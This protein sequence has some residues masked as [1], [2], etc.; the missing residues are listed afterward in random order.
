MLIKYFMEQHLK[1][2]TF[3][4]HQKVGTFLGGQSSRRALFLEPWSK[5]L[6]FCGTPFFVLVTKSIQ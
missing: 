4:A 1:G 5:A 6:D 2:G 3:P